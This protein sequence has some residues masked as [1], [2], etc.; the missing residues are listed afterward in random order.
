MSKKMRD[1]RTSHED[2]AEECPGSIRLT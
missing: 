2:R 1:P